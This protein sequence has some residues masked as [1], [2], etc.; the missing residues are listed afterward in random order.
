MIYCGIDLHSN[1]MVIV[2]IND[3]SNVARQAKLPTSQRSLEDFF[4]TFDG[5]TRAVVA[6]EL[7]KGVWHMLTKN[8]EYKG[9][10][11]RD[12]Y[13]KGAACEG[14]FPNLLAP[15]YKPECLSGTPSPCAGLG[16]RPAGPVECHGVATR[17]FG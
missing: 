5:P 1:N 11:R 10:P 2:A 3:N 13:G 16:N 9:F 12:P 8:Q 4:G 6:K 17:W 7:A 15:A 14:R